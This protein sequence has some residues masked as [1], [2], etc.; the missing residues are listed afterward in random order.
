MRSSRILAFTIGGLWLLIPMQNASAEVKY[1]F[2]GFVPFIDG[3]EAVHHPVF[4]VLELTGNGPFTHLNVKSLYFTQAGGP[5]FGYT[6]D[7]LG[8]FESS[9]ISFVQTD[10]GHL[11]SSNYHNGIKGWP[12]SVLM[13]SNPPTPNTGD[14]I[15]S[16]TSQLELGFT[17]PSWGYIGLTGTQSLRSPILGQWVRVVPEPTSLSLVAFGCLCTFGRRACC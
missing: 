2:V 13:D 12:T 8:S 6:G 4:A 10:D 1:D 16:Y 7:Y 9:S 15:L 3:P 11:V 17:T 14:V 5:V